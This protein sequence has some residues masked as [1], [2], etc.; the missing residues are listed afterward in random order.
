MNVATSKPGGYGINVSYS[1]IIACA[2]K[3]VQTGSTTVT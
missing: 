3:S 2:T 1:F